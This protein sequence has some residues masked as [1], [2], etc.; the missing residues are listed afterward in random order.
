[1]AAIGQSIQSL[2]AQAADMSTYMIRF[3]IQLAGALG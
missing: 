2:E 1:M 3:L